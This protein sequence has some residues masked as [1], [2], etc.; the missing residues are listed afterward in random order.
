MPAVALAS[1]CKRRI[2]AVPTIATAYQT[3]LGL[4]EGHRIVL[5]AYGHQQVF[6]T[7][8]VVVTAPVVEAYCSF[9]A[10]CQV[11]GLSFFP[12]II[13][14][15]AICNARCTY[16]CLY[17]PVIVLLGVKAE[18]LVC[19]GRRDNTLINGFCHSVH[20]G[21]N[22]QQCSHRRVHFPVVADHI[23]LFRISCIRYPKL[24]G[25]K[26]HSKFNFILRY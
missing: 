16:G 25:R 9:T 19:F 8:A 5:Q 4:I 26:I 3:N 10:P 18:V 2:I 7:G 17:W 20:F 6:V 13:L 1:E 14:G 23:Q 22:R 15:F 11:D 21:L 24:I 12:H